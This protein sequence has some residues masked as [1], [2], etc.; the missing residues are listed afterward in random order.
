MTKQELVRKYLG[1]KYPGPSACFRFVQAFYHGEYG[2]DLVNDY[3]VLLDTF[4]EVKSPRL[5][6]L[7]MVRNPLIGGKD[8][9][10]FGGTKSEIH[11]IIN[12]VGVYLGD[13]EFMQGGALEDHSE[14]IISRTNLPPYKGRII[15]YMRHPEL[16][17][18]D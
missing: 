7:V 4:S 13:R 3:L 8:P 18:Q 11:G 17:D 14:V 9:C 5:G 12:H 16:N 2:I 15:G 10:C 1:A 6:D